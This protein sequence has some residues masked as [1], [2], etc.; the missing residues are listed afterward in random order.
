MIDLPPTVTLFTTPGGVEV[1]GFP[2]AGDEALRW[3]ERLRA[4]YPASGRWPLLIE[5]DTPEY[6]EDSFTYASVAE[7][8]EQARTLDGAAL[9]AADGE[10][11]LAGLPADLAVAVRRELAGEGTWPAE[12]ERPGFGLPFFRSGQPAQ[13]TVALVPVAEPWLIPVTLHYGGW[14]KYP[15]PGE[16]A[17]IMRYW[18][19]RYGAEPVV[20]TG[21]TVEYAVARPPLTRPDALALAW[22]YRLYNDGEYD[23]YRAETLTDLAG[24]LLGNPVWRMWW[25]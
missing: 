16:H 11:E 3:W 8:L 20:L 1:A 18:Q 2:A 17:A 13:V 7:S 24:G 19:Q 10:R 23:L 22:E 15:A 9:L 25:D 21:T 4:A 5:D 12:P 14:N 6:L